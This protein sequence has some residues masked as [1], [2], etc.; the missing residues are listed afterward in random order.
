MK[1]PKLA[2]C[3]LSLPRG[4]IHPAERQRKSGFPQRQTGFLL[5]SSTEASPEADFDWFS[6]RLARETRPTPVEPGG[7]LGK[8]GFRSGKADSPSG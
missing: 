8:A 1:T 7:R 6:P 3:P 4:Q 2:A 5:E